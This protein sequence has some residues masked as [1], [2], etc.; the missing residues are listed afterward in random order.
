MCFHLN[1]PDVQN[2]EPKM[3]RVTFSAAALLL[4]APATSAAQTTHTLRT[5]E[6]LAAGFLLLLMVG[7][8]TLY[9]RPVQEKRAFTALGLALLAFA[10]ASCR[11]ASAEEGDAPQA[12]EPIAV[13][14][15][16]AF[17][18]RT[19]RQIVPTEAW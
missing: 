2:G 9:S 19:G 5:A 4:L 8:G 18:D 15:H 12:E 17:F 7:L 16:G 1:R 11:G 3:R 6:Y 14:G 10:A 13:I